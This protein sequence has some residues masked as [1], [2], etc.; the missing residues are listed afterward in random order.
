MI[1]QDL[2][3]MVGSGLSIAFLAPTLQDAAASVPL[4]T[5]APSMLIGGVYAFTFAT[6]GMTFS[7]AG[8]LST[9]VMWTLIGFFRAPESPYNA[10][11]A[12]GS[13]RHRADLFA[14]DARYWMRRKR[15]RNEIPVESYAAD[16]SAP[17]FSLGAD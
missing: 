16:G 8:A 9:C 3:F 2:V 4:A 12:V 7:A 10:A 17:R 1:W 15:R 13:A 5:S 11:T 6:L 14:A